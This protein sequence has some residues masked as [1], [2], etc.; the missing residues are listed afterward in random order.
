MGPNF[1]T[2]LSTAYRILRFRSD[3][4]YI[5]K[6]MSYTATFWSCKNSSDF[7]MPMAMPRRA[8]PIHKRNREGHVVPLLR[9]KWSRATRHRDNGWS[10]SGPILLLIRDGHIHISR[11]F[12]TD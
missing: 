1:L 4:K 8:I 10:P 3:I 11:I 9:Q 6:K 12:M 2:I 5:E 7:A